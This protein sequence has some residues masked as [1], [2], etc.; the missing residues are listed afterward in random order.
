MTYLTPHLPFPP[1]SSSLPPP[2]S[3]LIVSD[4]IASPGHFAIYHLVSSALGKEKKKVI[5]VDFRNEGRSSWE[6]ILKKLGTPLPPTTSQS[7]I[8][9]APTSLPTFIPTTNKN[10]P[11]IF[12]GNG[13]PTLKETYNSIISQL[14]EGNLVIIDGLSELNWMGVSAMEIGKFVRALL[15]K[16][17]NTNSILVSTL[18]ADHLPLSS[19][20]SSSRDDGESELL[21]RLLRVGNV[22]WRISHLPSG[23]SGDVMGEI[24]SH[25]L[26]TPPGLPNTKFQNVP[27]SNPLQYRI[28]SSTVRVF[29]KGTGR[30]F[31]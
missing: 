29:A 27:R 20:T 9:I 11:R 12:D 18:H 7:F 2:G 21:D 24:S 14:T 25:L 17:R 4:T 19:T 31:L 1:S 15:S 16:V 23:R 13:S 6:S 3:H 5:W 22:W 30:G 10:S 8:H 28:E 26:S